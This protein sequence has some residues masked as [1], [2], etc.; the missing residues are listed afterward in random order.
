[1]TL[2]F[3]VLSIP[4]NPEDLFT[5]ISPIGK[6]AYGY[7]YKAIHKST[8]KIYAIK[9]INYFK[10]SKN[11]IE[12]KNHIR[13]INL[14]Y[15][16]VQQET[17]LMRLLPKSNFILKYF[18]SYF[19]RKTNSLWLIIEYCEYGS[20]IDLMLAMNRTFTEIEL[21][22]I[23]K[24]ILQGLIIIHSKNL[25]HRDIK[26]ANILLSEKGFAK[27]GDFGVSAKL[28]QN[29]RFR[30]SKKGSPYWMSPQ[31]I[32]K[33]KYDNKTDIWS[34]GITC[35]ELIQGEPP[36]S[37]LTP[38][39]V[40]EKIGSKNFNFN[41]FFRKDKNNYS[42]ELINFL[43][44]CLQINPNKRPTAN[45]LIDH[46]FIK[47]YAKDN[48]YLKSLLDKNKNNIDLFRREFFEME[49]NKMKFDMNMNMSNELNDSFFKFSKIILNNEKN[50]KYLINNKA[51]NE[52]TNY[53]LN[54]SNNKKNSIKNIKKINSFII[55]NKKNKIIKKNKSR[56]NKK[57]FFIKNQSNIKN[58]T[59]Y[60]RKIVLNNKKYYKL[61]SY[62]NIKTINSNINTDVNTN[63]N[64]INN[65]NN[66]SLILN[67]N[68]LKSSIKTINN[69]IKRK[70]NLK[71]NINKKNNL[72]DKNINRN[73]TEEH[74]NK[75]INIEDIPNLKLDKILNKKNILNLYQDKNNNTD[76]THSYSVLDSKDTVSSIH[77]S[78]VYLNE[79]HKKYF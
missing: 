5:L 75:T 37:E 41:D 73:K 67:S 42:N 20:T 52:S 10:E 58:K 63:T 14:C 25:I 74:F 23:I 30:F 24:M 22:T 49:D 21:A 43:D 35:I 19:S 60:K 18:G 1:M 31:V 4:S 47:K 12:N 2:F 57:F 55:S 38:D 27:I 54:K 65:N 44:E 66:F 77:P 28:E 8:K 68:T 26:G 59:V 46:L 7:V 6:G 51:S 79:P 11:F 17:S 56:N 50:I 40:M 36:N 62:K 53:S 15:S 32:D 71:M 16:T 64:S 29:F 76:T 48:I 69:T 39:E 78:H 34:L 3:D 33:E 72:N 70:V 45:E 61:N 13:N 9:I